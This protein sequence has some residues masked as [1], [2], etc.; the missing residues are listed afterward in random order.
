M[1]INT[2]LAAI[3]LAVFCATVILAPDSWLFNFA[4]YFT[5]ALVLSAA[6]AFGPL[7]GLLIIFGSTVI[8]YA[9]S[10]VSQI[11]LSIT[12]IPLTYLDLRIAV[13][14][15]SDFFDL[16]KLP[17]A[18]FYMTFT[19]VLIAL[20]N[21][22]V[23]QGVSTFKRQG[24]DGV[25]R[26]LLVCV[27]FYCS[28]S[29]FSERLMDV[30]HGEVE[31]ANAWDPEGLSRIALNIGAT[32][33]LFVTRRM[34]AIHTTFNQ[35][36]PDNDG[37]QPSQGDD[38]DLFV[39]LHDGRTKQ[40]NI[41]V[42]LL[43]STV[44]MNRL[45]DIT[46]HFQTTFSTDYSGAMLKGKFNVTAIGGGTWISEFETITGM[47]SQIFG[48]LGYYTHV[49]LAPYIKGSLASYLKAK[50]Y[51]TIGLN[52]HEGKFYNAR[53]AYSFYGFDEYFDGA[54]LGISNPWS[55][56]DEE[57][58]KTYIGKLADKRD[59]PFFAYGLTLKNH[60]P[61]PCVNFQRTSP[62]PYNFTVSVEW[63]MTCELN[64]YI[65]R[66]QSTERA[67]QSVESF[68]KQRELETGRPYILVIF[69]DHQPHSF[70][71]GGRRKTSTPFLT[72][73][74]Y[75]KLRKIPYKETFFQFRGSARSPF[76]KSSLDI[77]IVLLPT[78]VSAFV[79]D[80]P[81]DLYLPVNLNL[82]ASCGP[83]VSP[84]DKTRAAGFYAPSGEGAIY[85]QMAP[86]CLHSLQKATEHYRSL[87]KWFD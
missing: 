75:T 62:V 71:D 4:T 29:I 2:R 22:L 25:I 86:K 41:F 60:S 8:I 53:K 12:G 80:G 79:A 35:I 54:D 77:P 74:D 56:S 44:D 69:G 52:P 14:N 72:W 66:Q 5:V 78:L 45:F 70:T 18:G 31:K 24:R 23:K 42:L 32:P 48:Y 27:S 63:R 36:L 68:L 47:P 59:A 6:I 81:D 28:W 67:I 26:V 84:S 17:K 34:E 73:M 1:S 57:I 46:P 50:G 64:E 7:I 16:M 30:V 65:L 21:L 38:P 11:K 9:I 3:S 40:P 87:T 43:E 13:A 15:P 82:L 20:M 10:T 58:V 19:I 37:E 51:Q 61:H 39:E 49:S 76:A 85:E 55:A 83:S 33:F